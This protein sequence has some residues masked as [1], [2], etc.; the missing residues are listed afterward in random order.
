MPSAKAAFA[1]GKLGYSSVFWY[2]KGYPDW[3]RKGYEVEKEPVP[4]DE[5]RPLR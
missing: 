2:R 1:A 5:G 4:K 3:I